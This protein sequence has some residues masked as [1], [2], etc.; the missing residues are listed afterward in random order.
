MTAIPHA[1]MAITSA[2]DRFK[3]ASSR[4]LEA[5]TGASDADMSASFV[6]MR[7]TK[8]QAIAGVSIIRL[9]DGMYRALLELTRESTD[10][11]RRTYRASK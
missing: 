10:R 11:Q 8:V 6:N 2:L 7:E 4:A 5:V 9:S 3:P 1:A